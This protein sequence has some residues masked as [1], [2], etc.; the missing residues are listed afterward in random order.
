M[1]VKL[2]KVFYI[3]YILLSCLVLGLV[4]YRLVYADPVEVVGDVPPPAAV[5]VCP[6]DTLWSIAKEFYPDVHTGKAVE[7]IRELNP[8]IDPGRLQVGQTI[9]LPRE[10]R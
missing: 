1:F 7:A 2:A 3:L 4:G 8:G 5:T 6:G 10:V 9:F